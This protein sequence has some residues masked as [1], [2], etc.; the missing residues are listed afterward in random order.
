[1]ASRL[2]RV[3]A[4]ATCGIGAWVVTAQQPVVRTTPAAQQPAPVETVSNSQRPIAY[5]YGNVPISREQ[6]G[7]FLIARGGYEKVDLLVNKVIIE[8]ACAEKNIVI[9]PQMMEAALN[10]DLKGLTMSKE[11]FC[12]YMLPRY[13]KTLYEWMEDVIKPR[14]QLGELC[15]DRVKV[16]DQDLMMMFEHEYGERR[17]IQIVMW[18]ESDPLKVVSAAYAQLRVSQDEFDRAARAQANPSSGWCRRSHSTGSE[19]FHR[20]RQGGRT[21]SVQVEGRRN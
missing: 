1:M 2:A 21:G 5:V 12:K 6:L 4:V 14:M 19:T 16:S 17:Q 11:E 10:D 15:K 7:D 3:G 8:R 13:G 20:R 9:T 18:P